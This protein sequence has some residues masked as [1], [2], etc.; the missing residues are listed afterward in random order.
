MVWETDG[1]MADASCT[2]PAADECVQDVAG[3]GRYLLVA[4]RGAL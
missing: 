4:P 3:D 2:G 1:S